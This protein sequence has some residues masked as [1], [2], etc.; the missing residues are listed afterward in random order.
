LVCQAE[1]D[2]RLLTYDEAIEV[3]TM[4]A[5]QLVLFLCVGAFTLAAVIYDVRAGKLPN[6]LTVP[7]FFAGLLFHL[8]NGFW[9]SGPAG[10]AD[11]V[12]FALR[13]FATG[14]GILLVLWLLGAALGGDV[15]L[16][17]A[18][19]SW[20]GAWVTFQVLVVS[21]LFAGLCTL[22]MLALELAGVRSPWAR[23]AASGPR[24]GVKTTGDS[25]PVPLLG[26]RGAVPFGVPATL[27]T[28]TVLALQWAGYGIPW[29]PS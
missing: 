7:A 27:A 29:P 2:L 1:P 14:F 15:K 17:G 28:W 3:S 25:A 21:A 19:G 16:M 24:K 4:P 8:V 13:G 23:K 10:A 6:R 26:R 18:L 11:G 22:G 9:Q 20:L 5:A 12:L